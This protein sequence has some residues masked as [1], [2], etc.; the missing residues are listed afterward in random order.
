MSQLIQ[1]ADFGIDEIQV[2]ATG[3]SSGNA[4][5]QA[6]DPHLTF[7]GVPDEIMDYIN[8]ELKWSLNN[9]LV[10]HH[11]SEEGAAGC[12]SPWSPM[13][14]LQAWH[15]CRLRCERLKTDGLC[16]LTK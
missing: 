4:G 16:L 11:V 14:H 3:A 7:E 6:V 5:G 2:R 10:F 12:R 13:E 15:S 9:E 1:Y 8:T